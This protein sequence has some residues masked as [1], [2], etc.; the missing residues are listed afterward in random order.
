MFGLSPTSALVAFRALQ[1]RLQPV[2]AQGMGLSRSQAFLLLVVLML[3]PAIVALIVGLALEFASHILERR[4]KHLL[5]W[6]CRVPGRICLAFGSVL[7][8]WLLI[9]LAWLVW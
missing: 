6:L 8:F 9:H 1:L 3:L 7:V 4:E 2:F 5:A